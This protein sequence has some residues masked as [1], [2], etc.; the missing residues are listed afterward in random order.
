MS[1]QRRV[2]AV[3][4]TVGDTLKYRFANFSIPTT[5]GQFYGQ[6]KAINPFTYTLGNLN[7]GEI[8]SN[9]FTL[10]FQ[11]PRLK[12]GVRLFKTISDLFANHQVIANIYEVI[13]DD[14]YIKVFANYNLILS[15]R[16]RTPNAKYIQGLDTE[17]VSITI[18]T[19][20]T[21][22]NKA[23]VQLAQARDVA[24]L[25]GSATSGFTLTE[26][27]KIVGSQICKAYLFQEDATH[28]TYKVC[29]GP[30]GII[31]NIRIDGSL[32][33]Q[34]TAADIWPEFGAFRI[35]KTQYWHYFADHVDAY[36]EA[37]VTC[38]V[39]GYVNR[40]LRN[41]KYVTTREIPF[42]D[43]INSGACTLSN[44]TIV[45]NGN[46]SSRIT[47]TNA[48]ATNKYIF[49]PRFYGFWAGSRIVL[50]V[51]Y[52]SGNA[53]ATPSGGAPYYDKC[54][55]IGTIFNPITVGSNY[56]TIE[57]FPTS[58]NWED[59]VINPLVPG[60]FFSYN[61]NYKYQNFFRQFS[62]SFG[63]SL[64]NLPA[65]QTQDLV[66]DIESIKIQDEGTT[67]TVDDQTQDLFLSHTEEL[68]NVLPNSLGYGP[69]IT[70]ATAYGEETIPAIESEANTEAFIGS[71]ICKIGADPGNGD[72]GN[73]SMTFDKVILQPGSEFVFS[74]R[75]SLLLNF[76]KRTSIRCWFKIENTDGAT[77]N[78]LLTT[79]PT[80][81]TWGNT[82]EADRHL[83]NLVD[84]VHWNQSILK[85]KTPVTPIANSTYRITVGFFDA[86]LIGKCHTNTVQ[87]QS[88]LPLWQNANL[89]DNTL[90]P[91][92]ESN[93]VQLIFENVSKVTQA[94]TSQPNF[95]VIKNNI[96][97]DPYL[98]NPTSFKN[99]IELDDYP[100]NGTTENPSPTH[101][102]DES[103]VEI[104]NPV[105]L[106]AVSL[107]PYVLS[108]DT[109]FKNHVQPLFT[110]RNY[111]QSASLSAELQQLY[112]ETGGVPFDNS[113]K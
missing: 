15:G 95:K 44:A 24:P 83:M 81:V 47:F 10:Q 91:Q 50:R 49:W 109:T 51:K 106:N 52:I 41:G 20:L 105:Y 75:H 67:D 39:S 17:E 72:Y 86:K 80:L 79:D 34:L 97:Y 46:G 4:F 104:Y 58:G 65:P 69:Y 71:Y 93:I 87:G 6:L 48:V 59:F 26:I 66:F 53:L 3:V 35:P 12:N 68:S 45:D 56:A 74:V 89:V 25:Y 40:A 90:H 62:T 99:T 103:L 18:N 37:E 78:F 61:T 36:P 100:K 33:L 30:V 43:Q 11:N 27:P 102:A 14:D 13:G 55:D 98:W 85:F 73:E 16:V 113:A 57:S 8:V 21:E 28:F 22:F 96:F 9:S 94:A 19:A 82:S 92:F 31:D 63:F 42:G 5:D 32:P 1:Y 111:D 107:R 84:P 101:F 77:T 29:E 88:I 54:F 7:S 2:H 38:R 64:I 110:A 70:T 23:N 112:T 60:D 108:I 76:Y